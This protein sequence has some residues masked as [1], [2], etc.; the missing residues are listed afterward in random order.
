MSNSG[1]LSVPN[2][3]ADPTSTRRRT[4]GWIKSRRSGANNA[5]CVQV[6]GNGGMIEVR[7]SRYPDG[8]VLSFTRQEWE[9]FLDGA[10]DREFEFDH[11]LND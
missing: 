10:K 2:G 8:P 7:N 6:R 5:N 1:P 3:Q 9:A 11:L 4:T